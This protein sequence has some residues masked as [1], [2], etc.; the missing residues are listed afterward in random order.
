MPRID[1]VG[2][3]YREVAAVSPREFEVAADDGVG[4]ILPYSICR[5]LVTVAHMARSLRPRSATSAGAPV[6]SS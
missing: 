5:P 4:R 3:E 6:Q 2:I 1:G